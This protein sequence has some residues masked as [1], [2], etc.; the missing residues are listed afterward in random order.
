[1]EGSLSLEAN[2]FSTGLEIAHILRNPKFYYLS[3]KFPPP[4]PILSQL[5]P[6]NNTTSY[7]L[8]IHL[9]IFPSTPGSP[10]PARSRTQHDCHHDTKVKPEAATAITELLM[11]GGKTPETC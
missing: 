11:K 6:V 3:H 2:R 4:V 10:K 5:D 1:M 8:K 7:F 9:N